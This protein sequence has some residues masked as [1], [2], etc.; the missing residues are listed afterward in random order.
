MSYISHLHFDTQSF[1]FL[2]P[3]KKNEGAELLTLLATKLDFPP[4]EA[5][6]QKLFGKRK[7]V[8]TKEY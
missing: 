2:L 3:R 1:I 6:Q 5:V 4:E 7:I 8:L